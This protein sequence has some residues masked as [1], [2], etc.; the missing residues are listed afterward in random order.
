MLQ[1]ATLP[2]TDDAAAII[3]VLEEETHAYMAKDFDRWAACWLQADRTTSVTSGAQGLLVYQGWD[4]VAAA[5]RQEMLDQPAPLVDIISEKRDYRITR[6]GDMAWVTYQTLCSAAGPIQFDDPNI[7]ETRVV[8][9]AGG[10]WLISYMSVL[11]RRS[12]PEDPARVQVTSGGRIVWAAPEAVAALKT[13]PHLTV[14]HGHLRARRRD[15]DKVLQQAI[16]DA[17]AVTPY[18]HFNALPDAST[19]P[20]MIPVILGEDDSGAVQSCT[21]Y[22]HDGTTYVTFD[23]GERVTRSIGMARMVFG[24]S[25]AQSRLCAAIA[26]GQNLTTAAENLGISLNTARTHLSRVYDKT[27]VHSQTALVR[28]LLSVGIA[29]HP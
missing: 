7:F 12:G 27:G 26:A 21:V 20:L 29:Q 14:S 24:L 22:P 25:E 19:T 6:D 16:A 10:Q 18:E 28:I 8:E 1:A 3:A 4:A 17:A 15:W 9:R 23:D 5:F 11:S 13:H 2:Q